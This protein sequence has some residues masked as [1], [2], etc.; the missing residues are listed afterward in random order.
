MA[1]P[2][3]H[4]LSRETIGAAAVAQI[5]RNGLA[6]FSIRSLGSELGCDP[7]TLY[8][9][10]KNKDDVLAIAVDAVFAE[11][12][13][14]DASLPPN[15]WLLA[16]AHSIRDAFIRHPQIMPLLGH[17]LLP[18]GPAELHVLDRL[19]G[20]LAARPHELPLADRLNAIIGGLIGYITLELSAPSNASGQDASGYEHLVA[21]ADELDGRIFGTRSI[22]AT[23]LLP[24]G[25]EVLITTLIDRLM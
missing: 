21:H 16:T 10:V 2:R 19:V 20:C 23:I 6:K 22:D 3:H 4:L 14:P 9:Y 24:E 25:F 13:L 1:R 15:V 7:M 18:A 12:V 5:E 8:Q 11:V 17:R